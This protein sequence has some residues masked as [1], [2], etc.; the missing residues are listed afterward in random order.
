MAG[1]STLDP[2]NFPPEPKPKTLKGHD[3]A[4]LGP[5]DSSDSG[6]DL[7]AP[8]TDALIGDLGMDAATD[9][10]G[11][12]ER[13]AAGKEP[14]VRVDG[15]RDIDQVVGEDEAGLGDGLDQ[16]EEAAAGKTRYGQKPQNQER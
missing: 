8:G 2:D 4:S 7:A 14:D 11:T 6:S 9:R 3:T 10:V 13:V 12:G 15:D 1:S 5:S 16:A